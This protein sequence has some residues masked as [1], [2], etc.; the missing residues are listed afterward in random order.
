[1]A[2]LQAVPPPPVDEC[3][4]D[5]KVGSDDDA[6]ATSR[7]APSKVVAARRT[8]Q[9]AGKIPASQA[10]TQIVEVKKRRGKWTRSM[11]SADTTMVSSN[12][13]TIDVEDDEGDVQSPKATTALSPTMQA[14]ETPRPVPEA[15]GRSTSSTGLADD[16]GSNKRLK[17]A[18]PKPCKPGLTSATK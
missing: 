14:V 1:V 8:R 5:S 6:P 10:T 2:D 11:V 13:E 12:V 3:V 18:P 17:K 16:V 7:R 9:T 4:S 15:Q